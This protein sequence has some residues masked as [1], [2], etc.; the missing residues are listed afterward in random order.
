MISE[1]LTRSLTRLAESSAILIRSCNG[2]I[3]FY[4]TG[5]QPWLDD[6]YNIVSEP[7]ESPKVRISDCTQ[8]NSRTFELHLNMSSFD[9]E[10]YALYRK[11][12]IEVHNDTPDDMSE[13][14]YTRFLVDTPLMYIPSSGDGTVPPCGFGSFH[15]QYIIDGRL[16]AV[17]VIEI[18]PKC[19]S[20]KYLFWDPDLAFLS[21]GKYSA[22]QE[23]NW[24]KENQL[25]CPSLE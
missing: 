12:Q 3:N 19:L 17:G 25:K 11:Y 18:L 20:S 13:N 24:V 9:P 6:V 8:K 16:V 21:L 7:K 15:Q 4:S 23:I 14:L 1:K 22:L 10:E 2:H 5:K